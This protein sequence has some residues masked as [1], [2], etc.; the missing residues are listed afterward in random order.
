[1][2]TPILGI[3]APHPPIIVRDVGG[4]RSEVASASIEALQ[5][6]ATSLRGFAPDTLVIISPHT[7]GLS[8]AFA[9]ET[10]SRVSGT[11]G[12]FGASRAAHSARTDTEFAGQLLARLAGT[13]IPAVS[14]ADHPR[15]EPGTLDHGVIVPLAFLDPD[16][17]YPLVNLSLSGLPLDTHRNLGA[18]VA[19][20]AA[21]LGRRIAFIASGDLSHRLTPD[22]PAGYSPHGEEFDR[23]VVDHVRRGDLD[24]LE[25][26]DPRLADSAGECGLRSIVALSGA[27]PGAAAR[28][29][30]YEG[31]WGV[32]YL[33]AL[34]GEI[35]AGA[36][37]ATPPAGR[38]GGMAGEEEH[39]IA[40]LARSVITHHVE[41][42]SRPAPVRL[43]DPSLPD[44]AGAFVTLHLGGRLRGCVGTITPTQPSLAEEVA[45][46]AVKAAAKDPRFPPV[47]PEEVPLLEIKVDVLHP[48]EECGADQLDP[49]RY[50]VIVSSGWRRGLLLPDLPGVDCAERQIDIAR[51]KADI[52]PDEPCTLERFRVDRYA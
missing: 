36:D 52:S 33:T 3:I 48:P 2:S 43:D 21:E 47:T 20:T 35:D 4:A 13:G 24:A 32:G 27:L 5:S 29:L 18:V 49:S 40:A 12:R 26:I 15:L 6:A 10:S 44:R 9:V 37:R 22:A 45:A 39:E 46:N 30:A 11:L 19:R 8:D 38:K 28:V 50:G 7:P 41:R 31:P 17:S 14:R 25:R 42:G 51:R 16:G 1:M 34:V 23:L